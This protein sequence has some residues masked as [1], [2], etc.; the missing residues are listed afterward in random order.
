MEINKT[1]NLKYECKFYIVLF[2]A[3]V[4]YEPQTTIVFKERGNP[5]TVYLFGGYIYT[6]CK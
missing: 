5:K 4:F 6:K 1:M 3:D 2:Y